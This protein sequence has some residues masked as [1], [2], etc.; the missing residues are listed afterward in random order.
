MGI[1]ETGNDDF[2]F[3]T[4]RQGLIKSGMILESA[5][6]DAAP[7]AN[8]V[9]EDARIRA[10]AD[11]MSALLTWIEEGDFSYDTLDECIVVVAD[12][13]GDYE[14]TEEEENYFN[15]VWQE[16]PDALLSLGADKADVVGLVD[17]PGK[18]SDKAAA[19]IG[20]ELSEKMEEEEADADS[21]IAGFAFGEEAIL[22]SVSYDTSLHGILE[23]TYKRKKVVRNGQ[24]QVV[25][26]RVSGHVRQSA[27]QKASLKKARRK[28]HTATANLNRRK[29]MRK[30]E[31]RGL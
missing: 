1:F 28:S 2:M 13:D 25:R 26:K 20:K 14:I 23:A 24:V 21:L 11:A 10:R 16:V 5:A 18:E 19:R 6:Q 27:A 22:E 9:D 12:I 30:R 17:G 31:Q 4:S 15:D 8:A 29:S 3:P 7:V